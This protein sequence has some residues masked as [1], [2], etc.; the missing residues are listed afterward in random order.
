M[1]LVKRG[2]SRIYFQMEGCYAEQKQQYPLNILPNHALKLS[3]VST[4][5]DKKMKYANTNTTYK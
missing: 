2:S 5:H 4:C 3:K 1:V